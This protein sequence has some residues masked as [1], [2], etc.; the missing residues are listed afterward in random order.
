MEQE[1]GLVL[2]QQS[3]RSQFMAQWLKFVD[4]I[5]LFAG[6]SRKKGVCTILDGLDKD[7]RWYIVIY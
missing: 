3:F 2:E 7:G 6:H 5:L 1:L 4:A